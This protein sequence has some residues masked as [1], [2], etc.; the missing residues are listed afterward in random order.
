M[1]GLNLRVGINV[2]QATR[3]LRNLS[4][5]LKGVGKA[6]Q[7]S[8]RQM[9]GLQAGMTSSATTTTARIC[10]TV[11]HGTSRCLWG[12]GRRCKGAGVCR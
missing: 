9:K 3:E 10:T 6:A 12:G 8:N 7:Q 11:G 2:L 5:S 1:A 4:R